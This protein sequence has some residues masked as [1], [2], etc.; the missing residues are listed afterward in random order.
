MQWALK[1]NPT[2]IV[3]PVIAITPIVIIPFAH[4]M[5]GER[6]TIRSLIGGVTAVAGVVG[7]TLVAP[8]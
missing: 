4:Y 3:L 6:P 1:T 7:L 2:G 8:R 5:E